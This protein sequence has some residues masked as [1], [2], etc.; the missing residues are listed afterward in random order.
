[1]KPDG[2]AAGEMAT[3]ETGKVCFH[4]GQPCATNAFVAAQKP[5][6]CF[7]CK[8]VYEILQE[9]NLCDY[10][11]FV[12]NPGVRQENGPSETFAYLDEKEIRSKILQFDLPH[13]ARVQFNVPAIHCISCVWLLENLN[14]LNAAI[15]R[16]RVNFV[17]KTV[18]ID[19][20]PDRI[21]LSE[22]AKLLS[23]TGYKPVVALDDEMK[24]KSRPKEGVLI[25]KLAVAGFA[26]G[27]IMLLSFPEYLGIDAADSSLRSLFS[28]LSIGLSI[29]VLLYSG[30]DYFKAT[31]RAFGQ[32]QINIDVPI[33]IGLL[34]LFARS[35]H[36]IL[37]NTG[38]GYLDSLAGLVFFL[39]IGRWFQGKTYEN[40]AFD[41]D[42]RS[43]F[44]LAVYKKDGV[45][46]KAVLVHTLK[47]GDHIRIRNREIVPADSFL[48]DECASIDYS[49]VT[50]ESTPSEVSAGEL[51]YAGGRLLGKSVMMTVSKGSAQS[52]LTSLWNNEIFEKADRLGYKSLMD[53]VAKVFTWSVLALALATG[54]YWFFKDASQVGVIVTSVLMVACPCALALAAPFTYGTMLRTMGLHGLYLKNAEVVEKMA[55]ID[56][57]VFDKTGTITHGTSRIEWIGNLSER[58]L[59]MVKTLAG[60]STHPL[61]TLVADS[62]SGTSQFELNSFEERPGQGI[63][64]KV[65][66][67]VLRLGSADF[68]NAQR[69]AHAAQSKVYVAIDGEVRG[70]FLVGTEIRQ[71]MKGLVD[72]LGGKVKALLSGDG[73]GE[74][75]RMQFLF[76]PH[77][78]LLFNQ[79]PQQKLDYIASLQRLGSSVMMLGDGI[80]D[81]GALKQSN[82]GIAIT[83]DTSIFTPACDGMLNGNKLGSIPRFLKLAQ[84]AIVI[85]KISLIISLLYNAVGLY[86]AVTGHLTPLV[87][88]ILMPISSISVVVFTTLSVNWFSKH[89]MK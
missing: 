10:Y 76:H 30:S 87:A 75:E 70:Y 49:F 33:A 22:V 71:G 39:L 64:G 27:N 12:T 6:C 18:A 11:D 9:N 61:S 29:P 4:C 72:E 84:A 26:F 59:Q 60:A 74:R 56:A 25:T 73:S 28:Y 78:A 3:A 46:W 77:T 85:L 14:R 21:A 48:L 31:F 80:N 37:L 65:N 5:F 24:E 1:M 38:G 2:N 34:V 67:A 69:A 47:C 20:N 43:Y 16:S 53:R 36:D 23:M 19:F 83:D 86:F 17:R 57:V 52:Y 42:Y 81:S 35:V 41:R 63:E 68:V 15:I 62:I 82:V 88:A 32:R 89:I 45:D 51:I 55:A 40:L 8:T 58:E 79:S 54:F 13:M 7:G 50:G 66:N 44:P